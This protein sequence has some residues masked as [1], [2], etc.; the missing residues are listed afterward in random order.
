MTWIDPRGPERQI[1]ALAFGQLP[2]EIGFGDADI[3]TLECGHVAYLN[4]IFDHKV[5]Q[6]AHCLRCKKEN[7]A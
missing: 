5:G 2:P 1:V 3:A 6:F 4:W 7:K